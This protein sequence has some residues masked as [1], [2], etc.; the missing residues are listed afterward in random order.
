LLL[1]II[2]SVYALFE[3]AIKVA[4]WL[5]LL[6]LIVVTGG[7]LLVLFNPFNKEF[8]NA[9]SGRKPLLN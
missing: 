4:I 3:L 6:I 5:G 9:F 7:L 8:V 2:V 1:L